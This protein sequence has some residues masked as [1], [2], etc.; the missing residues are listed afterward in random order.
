MPDRKDHRRFSAAFGH[1]A[2]ERAE[3]PSYHRAAETGRPSGRKAIVERN[4]VNALPEHVPTSQLFRA[5]LD[6]APGER[7]SVA[8]LVRSLHERSFGMIL[9]LLGVL[10]VM[11]GISIFA[12]LLL[13][14]IGFQ[15]MLAH[16]TPVLPR[17]IADRTVPIHR[18]ALL[19]ERVSPVI[20]ALEKFIRPRWHT[21]FVVTKRIVGIIVL[22]L[23]VTLFLP[24]PLTNIV[25]GLIIMLIAVAYL[26]EDGV[27]LSVALCAALPSL[28]ITWMEGWAAL[29][30]AHFLFRS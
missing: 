3:R 18:M 5:I 13:L 2:S 15:M 20:G 22:M 9:L 24:I 1:A 29:Q 25:P 30:S 19:I 10:A 21:P 14:A 28:A 16:E 12:G 8:W 11:P 7:V 17:I 4:V 26:E 6:N 27:L 23:A